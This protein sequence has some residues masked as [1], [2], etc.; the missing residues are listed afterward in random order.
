MYMIVLMPLVEAV[1]RLSHAFCFILGG[2]LSQ[3]KMLYNV[4]SNLSR[5]LF[6]S[7]VLKVVHVI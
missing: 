4:S 6:I 1:Y 7:V 3:N 2:I 5:V